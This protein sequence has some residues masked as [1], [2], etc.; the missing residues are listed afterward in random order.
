MSENDCVFRKTA[1]GEEELEVVYEQGMTMAF[2]S[3]GSE[4]PAHVFVVPRDH[5]S[6]LEE[7]GVAGSGYAFGIN[8][9]SDVRQEGFQQEGFHLRAPFM[10]GRKMRIA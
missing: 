5:V 8:D 3:L 10:S 9:G 6:S 4:A 1:N 2:D 7:T